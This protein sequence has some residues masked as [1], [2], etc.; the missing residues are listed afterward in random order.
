M[1]LILQVLVEKWIYPFYSP[2]SVLVITVNSGGDENPGGL[3]LSR[4][5][6]WSEQQSVNLLTYSSS[7]NNNPSFIQAS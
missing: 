1:D 5:V 6:R 2:L 7:N 3:N 4:L